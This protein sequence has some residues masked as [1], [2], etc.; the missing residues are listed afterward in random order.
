MKTT[1]H[2]FSFWRDGERGTVPGRDPVAE[3]CLFSSGKVAVAWL[4]ADRSVTVF[5][6]Y[7][8][9]VEALCRDGKTEVVVADR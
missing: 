4:T 5:D 2:K 9:A 8:A 3:G 1:F 7:Q 6:T